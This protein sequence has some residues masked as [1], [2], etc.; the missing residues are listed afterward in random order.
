[1]AECISLET[2]HKYEIGFGSIS[3]PEDLL[4]DFWH[5][6]GFGAPFEATI[7]IDASDPNSP[8]YCYR[9]T[10]EEG[11]GDPYTAIKGKKPPRINEGGLV[12]FSD[13][14][15]MLGIAFAEFNEAFT[16]ALP[17]RPLGPFTAF[18]RHTITGE[19]HQLFSAIPGQG[20]ALFT[21]NNQDKIYFALPFC[22]KGEYDFF[23]K[24]FDNNVLQ[25]FTLAKAIKILHRQRNDKTMAIRA[26]L[27]EFWAAGPRSDNYNSP[28]LYIKNETTN[29]VL[30]SMVGEVFNKLWFNDYTITKAIYTTDQTTLE[31]ESTLGFPKKGTFIVD[32][33]KVTYTDKTDTS[34]LGCSGID[35]IIH[36]TSRVHFDHQEF[37]EIDNYWKI[38]NNKLYKPAYVIDDESWLRAFNTI[39]FGEHV[40]WTVLF[41]YYRHLF[42][43]ITY[44]EDVLLTGSST[45]SPVV[46]DPASSPMLQNAAFRNRL[47][48]IN[49][50]IFKTLGYNGNRTGILLDRVGCTY[51]NG[52][53]ENGDLTKP[54]LDNDTIYSATFLPFIIKKDNNGEFIFDLEETSLPT[55]AGFIDHD[56]I[57]FNIYFG[58][59]EVGPETD[60]NMNKLLAAG[61][62]GFITRSLDPTLN[63][64]WPVTFPG[65]P[66]PN[67]FVIQ[68]D[69]VFDDQAP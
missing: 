14:G 38:L 62:K 47:V 12:E 9:N 2:N 4:P 49:G 39:E 37:S 48:E 60:L 36:P 55:V 53:F 29:A 68:P 42:N 35:K 58:G 3:L 50:Q 41:S 43:I 34:F 56:F 67:Q 59:S 15:G 5:D 69:N 44:T 64:V 23:L 33:L 13:N 52:A 18:I 17:N 6:H 1:M 24:W 65:F 26:N 8:V 20:Y 7:P 11:F 45:I 51:W 10:A 66:N 63:S 27:P 22:A 16:N 40:C 21:T 25:T 61:I 30:T 54:V 28:D 32:G 57:D 46:A 19:E 31:V